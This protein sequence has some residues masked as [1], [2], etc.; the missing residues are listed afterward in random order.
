MPD[1][2]RH[3]RTPV[4]QLLWCESDD[5]TV[6]VQALNASAGGLFIR[7]PSPPEVGRRLRVT[8]DDAV[9]GTV[10]ANVEVVWS[11][12][13]SSNAAPS[14]AGMG[15]RIV[16]F[17][18]GSDSYRRFVDRNLKSSSPGFLLGI[19]ASVAGAGGGGADGP[20]ES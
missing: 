14:E 13:S 17:E 9:G 7:T 10:V 8:F 12:A 19:E 6:Y 11:R 15:V 18:R 2:R 4:R 16:G 20:S 1:N 3:R 5:L